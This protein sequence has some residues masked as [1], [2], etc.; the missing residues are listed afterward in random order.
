[1]TLHLAK[2]LSEN[3]SWIRFNLITTRQQ[4]AALYES[5][6]DK[7]I[8]RLIE[9]VDSE[10]FT[11]MWHRNPKLRAFTSF[12]MHSIFDIVSA[13]LWGVPLE[14]MLSLQSLNDMHC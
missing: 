13:S 10:N 2:I 6:K 4:E 12:A 3:L 14:I 7:I 9:L 11:Q 8:S 1:M 5:Q